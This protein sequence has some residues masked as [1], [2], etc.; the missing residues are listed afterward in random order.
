MTSDSLL[1]VFGGIVILVLIIIA[2]VIRLKNKPITEEDQKSAQE[3]LEGLSDTFYQ[4]IVDIINNID[5]QNYQSLPEL[6]VDILNTIYDNTWNYVE[7]QLKDISKTDVLTALALKI[8]NKE[9]VEKFIDGII[10]KYDINNK[11]SEAWNKYFSEKEKEVIEEDKKLQ[12]Q[13]SDDEKYIT[14]ESTSEDLSPVEKEE[15]SEEELKNIIPPSEE[16]P[17]YD[18]SSDD[19]VEVVGEETTTVEETNTPAEEI[20]LT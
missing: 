19:S 5:F 7:E 9:Y 2:V 15:P 8:L 16:E 12:E 1:T 11:I 18:A 17:D 13:F 14:E 3:F 6:E 4:N 10:E 20:N